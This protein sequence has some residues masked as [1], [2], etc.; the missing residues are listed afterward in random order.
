MQLNPDSD[1][2]KPGLHSQRKD[3]SEFVQFSRALFK[4]IARVEDLNRS[5]AHDKTLSINDQSFEVAFTDTM[6]WTI[7][8]S[9]QT[10]YGQDPSEGIDSSDATDRA[11]VFSD[12]IVLSPPDACITKYHAENDS[13][14]V[15]AQVKLWPTTDF[16]FNGQQGVPYSVDQARDPLGVYGFT[17][18]KGEEAVETIV[19]SSGMTGDGG[20]L[21]ALPGLG[22]GEGS[23]GTYVCLESTACPSWFSRFSC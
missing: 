22:S 17:K 11:A 5:E 18:A 4:S 10:F 6:D 14:S 21:L 1:S 23:L 13:T 20:T 19:G 8:Y 7:E 3:P 12:Q 2:V 15:F 16:V 9:L